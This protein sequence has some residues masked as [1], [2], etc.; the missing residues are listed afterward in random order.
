MR[1]KGVKLMILG[2]SLVSLL[3]GCGVLQPSQRDAV[4]ETGS[5]RLEKEAVADI[6]DMGLRDRD[7]LYRDDDET[8]VVTMYLTVSQG[9]SSENTN[10]TWE[11]I[12]T[13]SVYDY[14][15]M[16]VE[17][18]QVNGLLQVGDENGPLSG[19]V[20]Y[21]ESVPNA[22]VQVRGQTS[23]RYQQKNYKIELKRNKGTWN[24][25]RTINLNKHQQDGLRFRNKLSY[26]LMKEIP[27]MLSLRT[28]FV[29]LYVKDET[30]GGE[31]VFEDYGLYTQV[32]QLN[33]TGMRVHGLDSNGQ[34]YK[35]NSF[36]FY[37]YEED[38][39]LKDDPEYDV[40]KFE[41]RL[42]IKGSDDHEKLI[43]MLEAVNDTSNNITDL[44]DQYFDMENLTY[45]MAFHI[46]MGNQDTQNR[47][48]YLYSP[49]NSDTWYF[50]SWDNDGALQ[51]TEN[52][53]SD[54]KN[55]TPW[56][57]GISN[58]WGN[59]LFQRCLKSQAF[60]EALDNAIEDLRANYV[61]R[62][63]INAMSEKYRGVVE[64]YVYRLPDQ[65]N[66]PLTET[67]YDY[68]AG[69]I[70]DE[71]E[72]NYNLYK[73]SLEKPMPFFIGV[74]SIDGDK[75]KLNWNVSYDFA[76]QDI[77]YTVEVASDYLFKDVIYKA[78]N[79][80]LPDAEMD[81]PEPG[82]YFVRVR[83][84]NKSGKTQDAFDYYVTDKGKHSGMKCFYV[85]EGGLIE[86]DIY[87]E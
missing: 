12:N 63:K 8:S 64:P 46:L 53:L 35:I 61:T 70:G 60:R 19:Q 79:I 85:R 76:A 56:E 66:A 9:N 28:Q 67:E 52:N 57:S 6:K 16:G 65:L 32:E 73:E 84:T 77:T 14:D 15:R 74:P 59:V 75:L 39:K 83:A 62:E 58:Y 11:E 21:G 2:C 86:E 10:H 81:V 30:E 44:M 1:K 17:R 40:K 22:T 49:L 25:Q 48:M 36:E 4:E 47:N 71:I 43:E 54:F 51:Y 41:A 7:A 82:Q 20:G 34:M 38:I 5:E 72:Y 33:K 69:V 29:H 3:W 31:G 45:W 50:I 80:K 18:Y 24:D 13:Y 68:V 78:E 27:Q 23:S 42:E 37:R 26:D 55:T 87:E